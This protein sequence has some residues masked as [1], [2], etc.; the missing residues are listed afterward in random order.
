MVRYVPIQ[1]WGS[2]AEATGSRVITSVVSPTLA[3]AP[4]FSCTMHSALYWRDLMIL[5]VASILGI[6]LLFIP[7]CYCIA[8]CMYPATCREAVWSP[9]GRCVG[10][11]CAVG[12][13]W[14]WWINYRRENG[15]CSSRWKR[16]AQVTD[17]Y[18]NCKVKLICDWDKWYSEK[19]EKIKQQKVKEKIRKNQRCTCIVYIVY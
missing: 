13:V 8:L 19:I 15:K 2:R 7:Y 9:C 5:D 17:T 3:D 18:Y 16:L 12:T 10:A 1:G 6:L 14:K 11:V 4:I